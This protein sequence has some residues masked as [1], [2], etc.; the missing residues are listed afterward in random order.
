MM[1][2]QKYLNYLAGKTVTGG[3]IML[4]IAGYN[5]GPGNIAKWKQ[6]T[7][8]GDDWL[9]FMES[10]PN[11]QNRNYVE[12]VM[13]NLWVYRQRFGQAAPSLDQIAAGLWPRYAALDGRTAS[14]QTTPLAGSAFE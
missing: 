1:L 11:R 7:G 4:V 6:R 12:R 3:N 8:H 10:I 13:A 14:N 9:L 5:A 2:G